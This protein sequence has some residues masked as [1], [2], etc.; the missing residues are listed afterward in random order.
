MG[1]LLKRLRFLIGS[2]HFSVGEH[3]L[4]TRQGTEPTYW[5]NL[6]LL[7]LKASGLHL[8]HEHSPP[9]FN[10]CLRAHSPLKASCPEASNNQTK[11]WHHGVLVWAPHSV[12]DIHFTTCL[13]KPHQCT[14]TTFFCFL[15]NWTTLDRVQEAPTLYQIPEAFQ[16]HAG[17]PIP[18]CRGRS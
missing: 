10:K 13:E 11:G 7:F 15:K 2:D 8:S 3:G 6:F 9:L 18:I 16:H 14:L 1:A 5:W 12:L 4:K 17:R